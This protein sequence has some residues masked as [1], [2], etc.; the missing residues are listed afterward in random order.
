MAPS[1]RVRI[2]WSVPIV[3]CNDDSDIGRHQTDN[4][5]RPDTRAGI[6]H[7]VRSPDDELYQTLEIPSTSIVNT[8]SEVTDDSYSSI[9][10]GASRTTYL[11]GGN[12]DH[13][14]SEE[15]WRKHG[16]IF[17]AKLLQTDQLTDSKEMVIN[18]DCSLCR[19]FEVVEKVT[20]SKL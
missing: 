10:D 8:F 1:P 13:G 7:P 15:K 18:H 20:I 9:I 3:S 14:D 17:R 16:Q 19:Y 11:Q 4:R 2:S 6:Q 5:N 12:R